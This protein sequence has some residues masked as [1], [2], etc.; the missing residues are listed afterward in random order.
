MSIPIGP[1]QSTAISVLEQL[2]SRVAVALASVIIRMRP[3]LIQRTLKMLGTRSRPATYDQANRA[4]AAACTVSSRC[5]GM[6]CVLRSVAAFID[7]RMQG[8]TPDWC[9]GFR[10]APF[11]AHAWIEVGGEPVGEPGALDSFITVLAVRPHED[12]EEFSPRS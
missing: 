12:R 10:P 9:T 7:C 11:A 2:R 3:N 5:A 4:R 1:E 6:G 8:F